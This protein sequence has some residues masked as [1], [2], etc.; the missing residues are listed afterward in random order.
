MSKLDL[1]QHS[2]KEITTA[3]LK[4][5]AYKFVSIMNTVGNVMKKAETRG[6]AISKQISDDII[7]DLVRGMLEK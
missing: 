6:E 1:S 2:D 7:D 4:L 3:L 5:D